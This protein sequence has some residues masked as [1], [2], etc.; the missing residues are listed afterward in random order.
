M[1]FWLLFGVGAA[2]PWGITLVFVFV[3]RVFCIDHVGPW[4]VPF[5]V[6][7]AGGAPV[8]GLHFG[9]TL[10][11]LR[12]RPFEWLALLCYNGGHDHKMDI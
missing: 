12:L 2:G 5:F 3:L 7:G 6:L 1:C 9:F 8:L 11:P 10:G 4:R